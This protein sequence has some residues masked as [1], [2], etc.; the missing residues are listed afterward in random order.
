MPSSL[1]SL[2][3]TTALVSIVA[4]PL[5]LQLSPVLVSVLEELPI[6]PR[7]APAP[8]DVAG[9]PESLDH[10][11]VI[12]GYGRVGRELAS[13]LEQ[14]DLTFLVIEHNPGIVGELRSRGVP[15]IYG[16]AG[17]TAVLAHAHLERA[18]SLAVLIPDPLAAELAT[19][20]ARA[21]QPDL[22]ILTRAQSARE[23]ERLRAAGA[24]DVVQPEFE[25]GVAVVGW[26]L[27]RYGLSGPDLARI[28]L[29]RRAGFYRRGGEHT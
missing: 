17:N 8:I 13:A 11:T 10:H 5:L 2:V 6:G 24:T 9:R 18:A 20:A 16:D 4:S 27:R 3:L 21:L 7:V 12:C 22:A 26:V 14:H 15:V 19:R 29:A 23:A 1:S 28:V 25:A